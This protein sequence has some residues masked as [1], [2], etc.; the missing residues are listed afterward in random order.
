VGTSTPKKKFRPGDLAPITGIYLVSHGSRHRDRHEVVIIRGE[1]LPTCRSCQLNVSYE[2]VRPISHIT[3]DWD[4]SG[5]YNLVVRPKHEEFQDFR[6]FRRVHLQLPIT[7]ELNASA[8]GEVIRGCSSDLSAGGMGAVI[9]DG[10]PSRYKTETVRVS[11]ERGRESLTVLARLRYQ[12]GLRHG[13]EFFNVDAGERETIR[14]FIARRTT[15]AVG[16]T[17]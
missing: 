1:Q 10:I 16:Q 2:I 7:L 11:I 3:H 4:F 13:F 6:L 9:Q 14:K 5:P 15:R 12:R 8:N 17:N